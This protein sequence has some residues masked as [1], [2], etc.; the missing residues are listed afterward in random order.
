MNTANRSAKGFQSE[1]ESSVDPQSHRD[2]V[3]ST[4]EVLAHRGAISGRPLRV[5]QGKTFEDAKNGKHE[6]VQVVS[7]TVME[8]MQRIYEH[9]MTSLPL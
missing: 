7:Q 8:F 6:L 2:C 5:A 1:S 4:A 3:S 9:E